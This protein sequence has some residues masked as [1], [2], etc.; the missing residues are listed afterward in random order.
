MKTFIKWTAG[1]LLLCVLAAGGYAYYLY[2]NFAQTVES[3]HQPL[4]EPKSSLREEEVD[5]EKKHPVSILIMG[6]DERSGDR[7]RADTLVLVTVNPN[8]GST[9][10]VSIPRDTRVEIIGKNKTDKINHS[11]AFGGVGTTT[12]TIESFLHVPIDYYVKINMEGFVDI[13]DTVGGVTVNNP[14]AFTYEGYHFKKGEITLN[15][16]EAL[17]YSRMR[18]QDPRGDAG[19]NDRQR[20]IIEAI[21]KKGASVSTITK[22]NPLLKTVGNNVQTNLTLDEMKSLSSDYRN[23]IGQVEEFA[24]TGK[25]TK[26]NGTYY[27]VPDE[28]KKQ[29]ITTLLREH[30]ELE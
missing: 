10:M 21:M 6:V 14:F 11:Y 30:L 18:K 20:Q 7:G 24:L 4:N 8:T 22:L 5:I 28:A 2:S 19:R 15:G 26:I 13:V 27:L 25:G 29:E 23:A 16:K 1:I 9:K 12:K 3:I 17:A